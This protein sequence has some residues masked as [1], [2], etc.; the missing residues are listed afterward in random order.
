MT[1][2][3]VKELEKKID[4]LEKKLDFVIHHIYKEEDWANN[5]S[6]AKMVAKR[7]AEAKKEFKEGKYFTADEVFKK[8][9]A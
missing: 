1:P 8:L 2:T 3:Q 7:L 5:P 9:G 6:F 4:K